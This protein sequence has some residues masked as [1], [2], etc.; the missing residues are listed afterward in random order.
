MGLAADIHGPDAAEP[1]PPEAQRWEFF[2]RRGARPIC[3]FVRRRE[4]TAWGPA[5][6]VVSYPGAQ[7]EVPPDPAV[8]WDPVLEDWLLAHGVA[9]RDE[10]NEVARF[11]YALRARFDAIERRRGSAQFVAVLLRCLYD[12]Q[13]ELYLPLERKLGAIRS[14]EPDARTANTA[15]GAELK[16]VLGSSVEALEVL[17]YPA[18][19][20]R[21]IFDGALAGYL[22][23]RFEL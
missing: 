23:E 15:V 9:A 11:A 8:A 2:L 21:T 22:R 13:C 16:L 17:G 1:A 18:E 14:Y 7:P 5:R 12:R 19:R 4:G 20:S 3:T 10:A 6:I